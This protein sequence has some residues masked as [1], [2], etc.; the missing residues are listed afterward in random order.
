MKTVRLITP[1]LLVL[2]GAGCEPAADEMFEPATNAGF[3]VQ[4][5]SVEKDVAAELTGYGRPDSV[6]DGQVFEYY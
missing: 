2:A 3:A 5:G 4:A 1:L 6:E